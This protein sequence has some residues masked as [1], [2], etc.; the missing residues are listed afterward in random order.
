MR[1]LLD[2]MAQRY[3]DR[4]IIFDSP[5][6]LLTTEARA[7]ATHMGQ[8]VLV[9]RAEHTSHSEV[10]QALAAIESCEI[11]LLLL[12]QARYQVGDGYGYGY[13]YGYGQGM[14]QAA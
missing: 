10:T 11:K 1:K 4:I 8:I 9:V 7:L 2:E 5:P 3:S 12:N 13:G 14:P 6:L